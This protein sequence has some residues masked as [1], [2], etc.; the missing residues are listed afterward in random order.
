MADKDLTGHRPID[1][2]K[3][4]GTAFGQIADLWQTSL[5]ALMRLGRGEQDI[6]SGR[7]D[8]FTV[9]SAD[10]R[11][12]RL[13][14]RNMVGEDYHEQLDGGLVMFTEIGSEPGIVT[15]ECSVNETLRPI[16]NDTYVGEVVDETGNLV[17]RISL[18][19]GS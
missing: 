9:A 11:M 17:A 16:T 7:S 14:A 6:P 5:L 19:A 4:W 13:T 2:A 12:P 1:L 8:R 18:D 10:G 15:V 3:V